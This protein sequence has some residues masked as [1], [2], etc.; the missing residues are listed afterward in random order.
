MSDD[1]QH[2]LE[3]LAQ[4]MEGAFTE[5]AGERHDM[6]LIIDDDGAQRMTYRSS[7]LD[8]ERTVRLLVAA[9][10]KLGTNVQWRLRI[11]ESDEN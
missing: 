10:E 2:A 9:L 1:A 8:N 5:A 11:V 3:A 6:I 4:H 7:I